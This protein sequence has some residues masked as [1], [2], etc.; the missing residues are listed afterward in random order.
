MSSA[1][2]GSYGLSLAFVAAIFSAMAAIV[3]GASGSRPMLRAHRWSLGAAAGLL[4]AVLY[5]LA[6]AF[7][8]DDFSIAYVAAHSEKALAD[9]KPVVLV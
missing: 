3:S 2:L 6:A 1:E 5:V 7:L 4:T 9:G 8:G